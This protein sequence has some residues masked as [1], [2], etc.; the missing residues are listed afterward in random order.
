MLVQPL[1][2]FHAVDLT[3]DFKEEQ[4]SDTKVSDTEMF[5][6]MLSQTRMPNVIDFQRDWRTVF[7]K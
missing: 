5:F 3:W 1:S 7:M 6:E 4:V 2:P